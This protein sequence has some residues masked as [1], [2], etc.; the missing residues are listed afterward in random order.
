MVKVAAVVN[1]LAMFAF[2]NPAGGAGVAASSHRESAWPAG[3]LASK[4]TIVPGDAGKFVE[5]APVPI[6]AVAV[7][8]AMFVGLCTTV[9]AFAAPWKTARTCTG[10]AGIWNVVVVPVVLDRLIAPSMTSHRK[11]LWPAS[12][13]AVMVTTSPG[14]TLIV[15]PGG[16]FTADA[17]AVPPVVVVTVTGW[18]PKETELLSGDME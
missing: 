6:L 7:A 8:P 9:T 16:T 13:V 2:V 14:T 10:P 4:V 1:L 11:K 5:G 15:G 17:N 12:G 18:V 3:R